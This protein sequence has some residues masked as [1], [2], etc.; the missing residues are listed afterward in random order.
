MDYAPTTT[1]LYKYQWDYV[2]DP[3][4]TITL[5]DDVEDGSYYDPTYSDIWAANLLSMICAKSRGQNLSAI[6]V[7][8]SVSKGELT[9]GKRGGVRFEINDIQLDI[10]VDELPE[11][12]SYTLDI[13]SKQTSTSNGKTLFSY[14]LSGTDKKLSFTVDQ[15]KSSTLSAWLD[16]PTQSLFQALVDNISSSEGDAAY[17][18]LTR[19]SECAYEL[20]TATNRVKYIDWMVNGEWVNN[21]HQ[22]EL[23][24]RLLEEVPNSQVKDL[25]TKLEGYEDWEGL[26]ESFDNISTHQGLFRAIMR[27]YQSST[28]EEE[29]KD[30]QAV[31]DFN[32]LNH[33]SAL[34]DYISV[35]EVSYKTN[36]LN[37]TRAISTASWTPIVGLQNVQKS[38][39]PH[40][41]VGLFDPVL[42]IV[43]DDH[44][45][46][47]LQPGTELTSIPAILAAFFIEKK[48]SE[49][50]KQ[51][52]STGL[53]IALIAAGIGEVSAAI[54][55][56]KA[57]RTTRA[58][59][60]LTLA[61]A[62]VSTA[63]ADLAC[64]SSDTELCNEWREISF[65]IQIGLLTVN[66]ADGLESLIRRTS[67]VSNPWLDDIYY[68]QKETIEKY[69]G[70]TISS[71]NRQAKGVFGEMGTDVVFAEKGYEPLH[72]RNE[73]LLDGWGE[74]GIDHI[75]KKDGEYFIVES[76]FT[77]Y[78]QLG[79]TADGL[80]MSDGWITGS[81]RLL[82]VLGDNNLVNEILANGYRR[83]LSEV[84]PDGLV[85]L[86]ELD[87][88]ASVIGTFTP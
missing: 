43:N 3:A 50:N 87:G 33:T 76:K 46:L 61:M 10:K 26:F 69:K 23:I 24:I 88:S 64:Q 17:S 4:A 29:Q 75:F 2:H 66:A 41:Q 73:T 65:Y 51:L 63:Y 77:G 30:I 11:V 55:A 7:D 14:T 18:M 12:G 42:V 71:A 9:Y 80:Q 38:S 78:A 72:I 84:S 47:G 19:L 6:N 81:G 8:Y 48:N 37:F 58:L 59:F 53:D 25:I 67:R 28:T 22:E 13:G 54:Q 39:T 15:S 62:D 36:Q 74:A 70:G 45:N 34:L 68:A 27:L 49:T 83:I 31:F 52:A 57:L 44:K 60:R 86:K 21:E 82:D 79:Q 32:M 1:A 56:Y 16:S 40:A 5:F 20:I 35:A 85:V